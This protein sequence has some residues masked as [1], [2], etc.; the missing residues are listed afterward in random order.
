MAHTTRE[1]HTRMLW[2]RRPDG[3]AGLCFQLHQ[4]RDSG[5]PHSHRQRGLRALR[6]DSCPAYG[7]FAA[8]VGN[9]IFDIIGGYGMEFIITFI[10]KGAIALVTGLIAYKA[11]SKETLEKKDHARI[12]GRASVLG[13]LTYTALYLLKSY[14]KLSLHHRGRRSR[15]DSGDHAF[16]GDEQPVQRRVCVHRRADLLQRS[17]QAAAPS[18]PVQQ[19]LNPFSPSD[20]SGPLPKWVFF[21][22]RHRLLFARLADGEQ[23]AA[24]ADLRVAK[25]PCAAWVFRLFPRQNQIGEFFVFIR[26]VATLER[27][28]QPRPLHADGKV[29]PVI[30][31]HRAGCASFR[32]RRGD[33]CSRPVSASRTARRLRTPAACPAR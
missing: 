24:G 33:I 27:L 23:N 18:R 28:V 9:A 6:P 13:A 30:P 5:F 14:I 17:A 16:Q 12:I 4:H 8:G 3:R 2:H 7:F 15:R 19:G 21:C 26:R 22:N 29:A 31:R 1:Q 25:Q 11:A 10:N 20:F 32:T